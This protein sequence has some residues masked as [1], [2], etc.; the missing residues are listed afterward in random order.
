MVGESAKSGALSSPD[1]WFPKGQA[2][3]DFS[4]LLSPSLVT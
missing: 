4:S 3:Q 2:R 1:T